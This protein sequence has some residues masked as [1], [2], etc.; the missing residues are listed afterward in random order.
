MSSHLHNPTDK[1]PLRVDPGSTSSGNPWG[2]FLNS[3]PLARS[4]GPLQS[5]P[6]PDPEA[7]SEGNTNSRV[8]IPEVISPS[9]FGSVY[10]FKVG[11]F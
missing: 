10:V 6:R 9:G 3:L 11:L 4:L 8:K 5:H 7:Q 2:A 1:L